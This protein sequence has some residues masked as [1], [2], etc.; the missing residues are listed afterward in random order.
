M[1]GM[2][3]EMLDAEWHDAPRDRA[4]PAR[5]YYP[6]TGSGPAPVIVFSHGVGG[7][8]VD[9]AY[10]GRHWASRGYVSVHLEHL[11]SNAAVWQGVSDTVGALRSAVLDPTNSLNRGLD[12]RLAIDRL[13]ELNRAPGPLEARIDLGRI[14]AAGHSFGAVTAL[15]ATGQLLVDADGKEHDL[16]DPRIRAAVVLSPSAPPQTEVLERLF[17]GVRVPAL[18]ITGT[19]DESPIGLTA[20]AQ[21]R[22]A[23]DHIRGPDQFLVIFR[24]ADHM[25]FGN[26]KRGA[27][28][29]SRQAALHPLVQSITT[30]FCDVYLKGAAA[31]GIDFA[32]W[33]EQT[34]VERATVESRTAKA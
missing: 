26:L 34:L 33:L 29:R 1:A 27:T 30:T 21:R 20:A 19:K 2:S 25:A 18:H 17:A 22:T 23:Y 31:P 4:V 32:A 10:L 7:S 12:V 6:T 14:G 24:D 16:A 3:V 8:R 9:Y 13:D 11:G 15:I 28:A 5:I